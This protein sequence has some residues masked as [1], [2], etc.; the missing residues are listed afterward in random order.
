[1]RKM[2][3]IS[4]ALALAI[5]LATSVMLY[6]YRPNYYADEKIKADVK[7]IDKGIQITL[8]SDD[9]EI[10]KDIQENARWYTDILKYGGHYCP[11]PYARWRHGL[12]SGCR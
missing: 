6:A 2:L 11:H 10:A 3:C 7:K 1:M 8:T 9:P 12:H 5:G 4:L